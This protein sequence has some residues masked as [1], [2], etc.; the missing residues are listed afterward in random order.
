MSDET[1]PSPPTPSTARQRTTVYFGCALL[2]TYA[3]ILL[4]VPTPKISFPIRV[5]LAAVN[6]IA[7]AVLWLVAR[8]NNTNHP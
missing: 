2:I 6:L 5:V 8:Q 1:P 7:A 4:A 3:V